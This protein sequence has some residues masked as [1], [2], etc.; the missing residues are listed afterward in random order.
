MEW[1]QAGGA[2]FFRYY[3]SSRLPTGPMP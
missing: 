1:R 3:F 2:V